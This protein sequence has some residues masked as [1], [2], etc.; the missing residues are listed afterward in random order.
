MWKTLER[1]VGPY[2]RLWRAEYPPRLLRFHFSAGSA[3]ETKMLL[4]I[5][6]SPL[7]GGNLVDMQW[8]LPRRTR[9]LRVLEWWSIAKYRIQAP[10]LRVSGVR[11]QVSGEKQKTEILNLT[12]DPQ[13]IP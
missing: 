8:W 3:Q 11:F 12:S 5:G 6:F 9:G 4:R 1:D 13:I 7:Y 2:S 10:N